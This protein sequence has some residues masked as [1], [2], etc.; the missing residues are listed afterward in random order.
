MGW[1]FIVIIGG[2]HF[3]FKEGSIHS[4][5]WSCGRDCLL[6]KG[7]LTFER[8]ER[9]NDMVALLREPIFRE[10]VSNLREGQIGEYE[11]RGELIRLI[12]SYIKHPEIVSTEH[13]LLVRA[14]AEGGLLE[15]VLKLLARDQ[16]D[17]VGCI[18]LAQ[19]DRELNV[20]KVSS[21]LEVDID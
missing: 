6:R 8:G 1:D 14:R 5:V 3:F 4:E 20:D 19:Q 10:I 11:S 9:K 18:I 15:S 13:D 2:G 12:E 21:L 16:F 7:L 17:P